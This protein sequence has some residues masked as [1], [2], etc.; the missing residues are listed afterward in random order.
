MGIDTTNEMLKDMLEKILFHKNQLHDLKSGITRLQEGTISV[1][2][3]RQIIFMQ[4]QKIF[5]EL[6]DFFPFY[7][8]H[9]FKTREIN[10]FCKC[11]DEKSQINE[12][13]ERD[14]YLLEIYERLRIIK[15]QIKKN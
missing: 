2:E 10:D 9:Q 11:E 8:N 14:K 5:D 13:K 3:F 4:R 15:N 1:K 6:L 7:V 12:I